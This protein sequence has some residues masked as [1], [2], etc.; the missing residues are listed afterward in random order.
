MNVF[1]NLF[2]SYKFDEL[3]GAG[4][5]DGGVGEGKQAS[6]YRSWPPREAMDSR[7]VL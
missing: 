1:S 3:G 5:G 4:G 6:D 7:S 2:A